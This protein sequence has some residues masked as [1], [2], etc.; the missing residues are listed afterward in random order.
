MNPLELFQIQAW[1]AM[2]PGGA[3]RTDILLMGYCFQ[4]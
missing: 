4:G 2:L 1:V 3:S